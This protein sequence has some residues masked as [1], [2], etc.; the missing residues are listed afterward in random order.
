[1][2]AAVHYEIGDIRVEE[3]PNPVLTKMGIII[4]IRACGICG[5][6]L[7]PADTWDTKNGTILGHEFSGD[8]VEVGESVEGIRVGDRVTALGYE[9]CGKCNWCLQNMPHRCTDRK[10]VGYA[11]PGGF[12][13]YVSIPVAIP[14]MTVFH[15]S[16]N[17]SYEEGATVEPLAISYHAVRQSTLAPKE[18]V[19]VLGA[20]MIGQGVMQICK[21]LGAA[22]VIISEAGRKR[23]E[24]AQAM[25]ADVVVDVT[26]DNVREKVAE[27][28]G[29]K[30]PDVV[31]DCAGMAVTFEDAVA[32][33]RGGGRIMLVG[34]YRKPITWDP[35][36]IMRKNVKMIGCLGGSFPRAIE[37]IS[38]GQVKTRPLITHEFPLEKAKDAFAMQRNAQEAVKVLIKP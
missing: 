16:D 32:I 6:D 8:V 29:G 5:S 28:T 20:G 9:N 14:K 19:A 36:E 18:T 23:L 25:G 13:E 4:K 30:G 3:R 17:M 26:K 15:L 7:H 24:I 38:S 22:K 33:V 12:A 35:M 31:V 1:M 37:F 11:F 2:K 21:A 10:Y 34:V 27:A